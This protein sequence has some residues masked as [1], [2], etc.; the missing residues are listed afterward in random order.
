[1]KKILFLLTFLFALAAGAQAQ[2]NCVELKEIDGTPDVKCVKIIKVTNGTLACTGNTC[3]ITISGG[4]GGSPGGA[5][6]N[7][8]YNNSGSFGGVAGFIFDGTSKVS[9]GV[10]GTSVGAVAFRNATSGTITV[11][12]VTGALGTVTLSLPATTGTLALTSQLTSGTVTSVAQS[13]TGGLISVG[14]SPIT[15]SGTLAL[16][17]AGT[18]GGIPYFSSGTTWASSAALTANLPVIGGGAGAAP[19]VGTRSGNTT[20]FVTTTGTLTSG[21]CVKIDASGNFIANG[22]ACG[23][24]G[25]NTALSNL[26]AVSINASLIPQTTLD[27]GAAATA[28]RN[29]YIYGGGTFGSHS[30][31]F[32]GT[33][34]GNRT[35]TFPDNTGT[36]AE[37]NLAQTFSAA[38]SFSSTITQTS[39]SATAFESGPNGATNPV[40]RL[41]NNTASAAT[42]LSITGAAAG[43]GVTVTAISSG[44]N[45]NIILTPKGTAGVYV[46]F[47]TASVPALQFFNGVPGYGLYY[48]GTNTGLG[49]SFGGTPNYQ[50]NGGT[51]LR[52]SSGV[53]LTWT[54]SGNAD[55]GTADIALAR[56]GQ[57]AT[58]RV[59]GSSSTTAAT[60]S[61]PA[62]SP[63]QITADQN[64]YNPGT[65]WFQ[66]WSSDASRNITGLVAGVDG[67]IIEIWNIGSQNIVL[68]NENASS[69]A[70]NRFTTSTGADLTLAAN[71]CAKARYDATSARWRAY[72]CN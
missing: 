45:E 6:T 43:S 9:L 55:T 34:T 11:Q 24:S 22:S 3:T 64:N 14:G 23:G 8:Q 35:A 18:S 60:F 61:T 56:P 32:D 54:N 41:V 47:G 13:F 12:P 58:V 38:Q 28:W 5:D 59:Q 44:S 2:T 16:T 1:M 67:Q 52:V 70:A 15:T 63:T 33:P 46:G 27:L 39:A 29:L 7:V 36:V 65:G 49:V 57:A 51:G 20:Q 17:V 19:T 42:G 72:L 53:A 4:G 40:F 26:A 31:K 71:K 48:G 30:I 50:F 37:L 69:T 25:A 62:L 10:A 68:Q 21:D 66:R